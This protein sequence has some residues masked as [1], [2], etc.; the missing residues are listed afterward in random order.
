MTGAAL[1][2]LLSKVFTGTLIEDLARQYGV[3]ER[4]RSLDIV[5]FVVAL[6]LT[7][8]THE[9]GRQYDVLRTYVDGGAPKVARSSFYG[10]FNKPLEGLL[11]ELLRRAIAFADTQDRLLPGIL[12]TVTD[13]RI[14]DS[15]TVR[16]PDSAGLLAE[17]PGTGDYAAIKVHKTYSVGVGNLVAYR[18]TPAR[19]HDG[20]HLVIDESWRNYGALVDLG[21]A[22]IERILDFERFGVSYVM[23][24]KD[25]WKPRVDRIVRGTIGGEI[26]PDDDFPMLLAE[27]IV[28]LDGRAID[29]DVTLGRGAKSV[30]ARL[31]GV[32]SPKGGYCFFLTNLSRRTHGPHQVGDIYRVR[33]EIETDNKVDKAGARLDEI[34]AQKSTSV[35]VL[36]LAS[37]LNASL[38]RIAV[39]MDKL[40]IRECMHDDETDVA[41][42]APMHPTQVLRAMAILRA[43]VASLIGGTE[44]PM[45]HWNK[46]A[47]NL[48]FLGHDPNWRRRPS[49]LDRLQGLTA[50]PGPSRKRKKVEP[51][52][53]RL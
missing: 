37:M 42:R 10:W 16:L 43:T 44:T 46:L 39:H 17:Y 23:R 15:T 19:D 48:R 21:Y 47:A 51:A 20:P 36:L 41:P 49:V 11:T 18:F 12:G 22:S 1:K 33:W 45:L 24:L 6:V 30:T 3:V 29:A 52:V 27:D 14:V 13:W 2:D 5:S 38:A 4:E 25:G 26:G 9:A 31:V 40:A 34:A 8:G 7:G 53:F 50:P 35:R 28:L 32:P